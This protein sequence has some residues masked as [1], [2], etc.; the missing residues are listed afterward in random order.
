MA[1]AFQ[2]II[3]RYCRGRKIPLTLQPNYKNIKRKDN[4]R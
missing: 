2:I 3:F 1:K 4:E